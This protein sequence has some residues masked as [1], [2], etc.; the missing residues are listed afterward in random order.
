MQKDDIKW[1]DFFGG[2]NTIIVNNEIEFNKF[3]DFMNDLGLQG[4]FHN[5]TTFGE[6][7]HLSIINGK[8]P[9]CII[10]E[11]QPGKGMTFGYTKESS[12]EWYGE[13]PLN[14]NDLDSFYKNSKLVEKNKSLEVELEEE[15]EK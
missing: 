2:I 15:I 11:Y 8:D 14:I 1:L 4:L 10:F 3:Y 6:W 12:K 13:E 5:T 9:N 7:Q